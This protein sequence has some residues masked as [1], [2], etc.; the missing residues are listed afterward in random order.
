MTNQNNEKSKNGKR[1]ALILIAILLL[2]AIA[3]GAYTYSRY[4]T[5]DEGTGSA[6]VARWGYNV[7]MTGT[8]NNA[9]FAE[10]Y[11][12][13][14]DNTASATDSDAGAVIAR[15]TSNGL[16]VAP[17]ATGSVSFSV[18]GTAE[19]KAELSAAISGV[20]DIYVN[21][22][23][24]GTTVTYQPIVFTLSGSNS[25]Q[26]ISGTISAIGDYLDGRALQT[27]E[28]QENLVGETYTL[29][30]AWKFDNGN[31]PAGE[32]TIDCDD[33]DTVLARIASD[34][35]P[36]ASNFSVEDAAGNTWTVD[37][38]STTI[39]FELTAEIAQVM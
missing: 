21:V 36:T 1:L 37:T 31:A 35:N 18:S 14:G 4:V 13:N 20:S 39:A 7:T 28:A 38:Y 23:N 29:S 6:T 11:S 17:G 9:G 30:W 8:S 33:L 26:L 34:N 15:V 24:N 5:R 19:V 32:S 27:Y 10:Y 25:G 3:F 22:K 2:V 16:I 12:S